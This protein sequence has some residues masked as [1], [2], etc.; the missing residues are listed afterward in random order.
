MEGQVMEYF[1]QTE[2]R[3]TVPDVLCLQ[4]LKDLADVIVRPV[5]I[6]AERLQ[7][8]GEILEDWKR[9]NVTPIFKKSKKEHLGKY[10]LF[11]LTSVPKRVMKEILLKT[12]SEHVEDK[13]VIGS[14]QYGF[15]RRKCLTNLL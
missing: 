7:I 11:S 1:Q 5:L 9:T 10:R 6:I 8:L 2:H 15:M 3:S 12:I 4:V 14:S 13:K